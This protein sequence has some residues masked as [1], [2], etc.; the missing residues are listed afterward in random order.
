MKHC[1][2]A[3]TSKKKI[4]KEVFDEKFET[5]AMVCADCGTERWDSATQIAF[6]SWLEKLDQKKRDRFVL[7]FSLSKNTLHCLD[8]LVGEFPGADRAKLLRAMVMLFVER[9]APRRDWADL[10]EKIAKRDVFEHLSIGTREIVKVHF[11]PF[12]MLD[13]HS[14]AKIANMKPQLP[15]L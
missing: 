6:S 15:K 3:K 11:N 8:R 2:H 10:V 4:T 7:Q 9:I 14:W 1:N 12:A 5:R 13:L